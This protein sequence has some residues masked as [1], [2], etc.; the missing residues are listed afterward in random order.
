MSFFVFK[1]WV[2]ILDLEF[3]FEWKIRNYLECIIIFWNKQSYDVIE[4]Y[5]IS[6]IF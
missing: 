3:E 2:R 1:I 6:D 5:L 4:K